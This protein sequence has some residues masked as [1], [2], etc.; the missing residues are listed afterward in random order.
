[1]KYLI[2]TA[3][4]FGL[5]APINRAVISAHREGILTSASLMMGEA[6]TK[7][8]VL[9]AKQNPTLAVGL[10]LTL[11]KGRS[12]LSWAEIPHLV[13]DRQRFS[14]RLLTSGIGYYFS[15][16][17]RGELKKECEAQV[18]AFLKTGLK[19]DHINGHNHFHIHP[20]LR[21]IL[22]ALVKKYKIPAVRIPRQSLLVQPFARRL[23]KRL[24]GLSVRVNDHLF[25]L[26]EDSQMNEEQWLKII[27]KIKEGVTEIYSHPTMNSEE[28]VA[29]KSQKVKNLLNTS[30]VRCTTFSKLP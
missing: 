27:P 5:T 7:E 23:A 12:V 26:L 3:D 2:V 22:V 4:D 15:K 29:L 9:L 21:D 19:L 18:E 20:V 1:M 24:R 11:V 10:H 30:G 8:A 17:K 25:G 14:E 13:D 28:W 6:A 16:T